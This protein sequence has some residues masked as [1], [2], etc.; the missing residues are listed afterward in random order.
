M[1][2]QAPAKTRR[3]AIPVRFLFVTVLIVGVAAGS[4]YLVDQLVLAPRR[5]GLE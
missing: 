2:D 3:R 1:S 5:Q 4:I